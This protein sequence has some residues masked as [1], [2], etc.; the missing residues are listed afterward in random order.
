MDKHEAGVC[1][2][3][4][5]SSSSS[6]DIHG[7][8]AT[9]IENEPPD[10]EHREGGLLKKHC[11]LL[12][13]H[14]ATS[15]SRRLQRCRVCF[16]SRRMSRA[17]GRFP[18]SYINLRSK[19]M[20]EKENIGGVS[21]FEFTFV[22]VCVWASLFVGMSDISPTIVSEQAADPKPTLRFPL[23]T[24]YWPCSS[25]AGASVRTQPLCASR[26]WW[27]TRRPLWRRKP[28]RWP[29]GWTARSEV[30]YTGSTA[31]TGKKQK[32]ILTQFGLGCDVLAESQRRICWSQIWVGPS[33]S[34]WWDAQPITPLSH[35]LCLKKP[36]LW[37]IIC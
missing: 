22:L 29:R 16:N 13:N 17:E 34:W 23:R 8:A 21:H 4:R 9:I 18:G 5:G 15:F 2:P 12:W 37:H 31:D 24:S 27:W 33:E 11:N 20:T 10:R 25:Q 26:S 35:T 36:T 28:S 32:T 3:W 1:E 19:N 6:K 14:M 7:A 30:R